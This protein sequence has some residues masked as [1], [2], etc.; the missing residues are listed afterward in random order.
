MF[1]HKRTYRVFVMGKNG[2]AKEKTFED[3]E[4]TV[5]LAKMFPNMAAPSKDTPKA[6]WS[7]SKGWSFGAVER[8]MHWIGTLKKSYQPRL[9]KRRREKPDCPI[10]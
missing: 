4:M 7:T 3:L 2:N 5:G 9:R 10:S 6:L 1:T 8:E